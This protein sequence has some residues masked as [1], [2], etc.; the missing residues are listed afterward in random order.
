MFLQVGEMKVIDELATLVFIVNRSWE[1]LS[2]IS[3]EHVIKTGKSIRVSTSKSFSSLLQPFI[4]SFLDEA[5]H[6]YIIKLMA[7]L[8][9]FQVVT[10]FLHPLPIYCPAVVARV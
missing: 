3:I 6:F 8:H 1:K 5:M 2:L 9:R 7:R 10:D 4:T